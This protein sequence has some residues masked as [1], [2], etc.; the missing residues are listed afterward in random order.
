MF[1]SSSC[2]RFSL[3]ADSDT[4]LSVACFFLH[5][6]CRRV[7]TALGLGI[8]P[9]PFAEMPPTLPLLSAGVGR[10][11]PPHLCLALRGRHARAVLLQLALLPGVPRLFALQLLELLLAV[12]QLCPHLLCFLLQ[13]TDLLAVLPVQSL[14]VLACNTAPSLTARIL[15]LSPPPQV[16]LATHTECSLSLSNSREGRNEWEGFLELEEG[17][18]KALLLIG[19]ETEHKQHRKRR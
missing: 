12:A 13:L 3:C 2:T 17:T 10:A 16:F 7:K 14:G 11:L 6:T 4:S 18:D 19:E 1:L 5:R 8:S 9:V 15:T